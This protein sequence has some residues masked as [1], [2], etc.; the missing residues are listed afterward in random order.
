MAHGTKQ[1]LTR[2]Q[3]QDCRLAGVLTCFSMAKS[4]I[5]NKL[6]G[7]YCHFLAFHGSSL[8]VS[9]QQ[10]E[11]ILE[12]DE[13][14]CLLAHA[15]NTSNAWA[16]LKVAIRPWIVSGIPAPPVTIRCSEETA[17]DLLRIAALHCQ[18]AVQKIEQALTP[19]P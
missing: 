19:S 4:T 16:T 7:S 1:H 6:I 3:C 14:Q 8:R 15:A 12:R 10:V 5:I 9:L 13:A 17:R 11:I 2:G 18:S